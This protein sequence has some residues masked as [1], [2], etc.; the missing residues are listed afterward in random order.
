MGKMAILCFIAFFVAIGCQSEVPGELDWP[1][2]NMRY[3][4][5]GKVGVREGII[6]YKLTYHSRNHWREEVFSAPVL[7]SPAG[8]FTIQGSHITVRN[9]TVTQYDPNSDDTHS[10]VLESGRERH[11]GMNMIVPTSMEKLQRLYER[12]PVAVQ[13]DTR[14]CF[15][16]ACQENAVG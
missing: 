9:G 13:T 1:P 11:P 14:L 8:A 16:N 12:E 6:E 2:L 5:E 10:Q 15:Q 7:R 3:Q 4:W